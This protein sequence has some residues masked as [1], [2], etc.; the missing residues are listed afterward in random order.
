M[1][2]CGL[3][4]AEVPIAE[5]QDARC[6]LQRSV[7]AEVLGEGCRGAGSAV[8]DPE[9]LDVWCG[10]QRCWVCRV[11]GCWVCGAGCRGTEVLRQKEIL[12]GFILHIDDEL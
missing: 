9:V 7:G 1:E 3:W 12:S 4:G 10:M 11:Q 2:G 5:V 6:R 8:R